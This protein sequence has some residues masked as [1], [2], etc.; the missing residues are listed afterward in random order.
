[1]ETDA[2]EL[3]VRVGPA[4]SSFSDSIPLGEQ[5]LTQALQQARDQITRSILN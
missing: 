1:M 4:G 5:T 3:A 2:A